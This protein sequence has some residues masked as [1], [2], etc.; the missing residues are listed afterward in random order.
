VRVQAWL[1]VVAAAAA[2]VGGSAGVF[3]Q[4]PARVLSDSEKRLAHQLE[5][6]SLQQLRTAPTSPL[7]D[8][9][10]PQLVRTPAGRV[11]KSVVTEVTLLGSPG[12]SMAADRQARVTRYEYATG[13]TIT[14]VVDLNSSQVLDVR[15]EANRPT[16]LGGDE[17]RRAIVLA[18]RAVA[19]LATTPRSGLQ[20]LSLVDSK[21]ASRHYGHR[22][23]VV[24]RQTPPTSP[25]VLVDLSTEQ[26]VNANF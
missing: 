17:V 14:T 16:P 7:L 3:A 10:I 9:G 22:L 6:A 8:K 4:S 23:V 21:P 2:V 26:V 12:T 18:A 19:D 11:K 1:W 15:A 25:R 5:E 24:W 13:L 20:V